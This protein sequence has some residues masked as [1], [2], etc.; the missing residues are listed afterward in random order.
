MFEMAEL[1]T[2]IVRSVT[3]LHT[4]IGEGSPLRL[5]VELL[6]R[7]RRTEVCRPH[8]AFVEQWL[9]AQ[10]ES[11]RENGCTVIEPTVAKL[12]VLENAKAARKLEVL[13]WALEE[14][15]ERMQF[16]LHYVYVL[17]VVDM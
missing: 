6:G 17:Q 13:V 4:R 2:H 14:W 3:L 5:D 1:R 16:S 8:N 9:R 12:A 11:L 7:P 15:R 10:D